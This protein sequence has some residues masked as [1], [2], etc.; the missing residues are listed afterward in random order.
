MAPGGTGVRRPWE[1]SSGEV[2]LFRIT[3]SNGAS[4][5]RDRTGVGMKG[6]AG[7][8]GASGRCCLHPGYIYRRP[9]PPEQRWAGTA[10]EPP[11][12]LIR[13]KVGLKPK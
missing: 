6:R 11:P 8:V 9:P 13:M 4:L 7:A 12:T 10:A 3:T 2:E 5:F 1:T